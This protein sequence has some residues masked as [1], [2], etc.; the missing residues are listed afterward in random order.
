MSI[1]FF[2]KV[3]THGDFV[4]RDLPR[5]FVEPW[6]A[7]L[8]QSIA[9]SREQLGDDWLDRYLVSPVWRFALAPGIC[10]E[11][12]WLGL[13]MPSVDRVG[14]YFPLT[15]ATS[16]GDR[17]AMA[18]F[19]LAD[20]WYRQA[21]SLLVTALDDGFDLEVFH[22]R[23]RQLSPPPTEHREPLADA[24]ALRRQAATDWRGLLMPLLPGLLDRAYGP[25]SLWGMERMD[26]PERSLVIARGLPPPGDFSLLLDTQGTDG[27]WKHLH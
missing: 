1:G 15:L 13:L 18:A 20:E 16:I 7:W 27:R 4:Q 26:T 3:H 12:A 11:E 21:A 23:L 5:H 24:L 19:L 25:A 6:D 17:S 2:G 22:D 8:Q 9:V 10:G 14:R